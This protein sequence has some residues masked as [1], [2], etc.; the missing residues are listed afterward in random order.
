[1]ELRHLRYFVAVA[2]ERSFTGAA[3][4]LG[5]KQPPLSL[6]I[7]RLEKETGTPLFRRLTRSVELTDAGKLLYE[8]ARVILAQVE[9]ATTDVRRRARGET[10][11]IN[12]GSSGGTYFHPRI[13]EIIR[14][15]RREYPGVILSPEASNTALLVARLRAGHVD[16]AFVRPPIA[17]DDGLKIDPLVDEDSVV[18]LPSTH[19]LASLAAAPLAALAQDVFILTPRALNPSNYDAILAA[20]HRAGFKPKLGPE[21]PQIMSVIPMVAAGLGVSL[22]PRSISRFCTEGVVWVAIKG[23]APRARISLA[24]RRD[25][26]SAAV[27]NFIALAHRAAGAAD[28]RRG[29]A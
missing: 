10:G 18:I 8:E 11:Q 3:K 14:D 19:E 15:Y 17:E 21:A 26:R 23:E 25:E 13:P 9:Q 12:I 27:K 20:C 7:Q 28:R 29:R 22:V 6:Q 16:V 5:I 24:Y 4:R 1:M 2:E